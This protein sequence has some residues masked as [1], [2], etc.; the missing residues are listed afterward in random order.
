MSRSR[1]NLTLSESAGEVFGMT[2]AVEHSVNIRWRKYFDKPLSAYKDYRSSRARES[3]WLI[4]PEESEK[5]T[6]QTAVMLDASDLANLVELWCS[7]DVWADK[8]VFAMTKKASTAATRREL[9][10]EIRLMSDWWDECAQE[11]AEQ[12]AEEFIASDRQ[13]VTTPNYSRMASLLLEAIASELIVVK[14]EEL[15]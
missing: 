3:G 7:L 15:G 1:V 12:Y 9:V 6:V 4:E 14:G 5:R 11:H 13:K 8:R 2:Y 10:R